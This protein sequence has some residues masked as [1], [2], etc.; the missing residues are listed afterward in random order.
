M[1]PPTGSCQ[2]DGPPV[3]VSVWEAGS[4]GLGAGVLRLGWP[5]M[6]MLG[7]GLQQRVVEGRIWGPRWC[8]CEGPEPMM[9]DLV[10]S[11]SQNKK[12]AT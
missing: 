6:W 12:P 4:L 9:M 11:I 7:W 2:F 8:S 1:S 5:E 10:E 3:R